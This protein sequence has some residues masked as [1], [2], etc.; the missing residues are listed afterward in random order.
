MIDIDRFKVINDTCG[1]IAGDEL[2]RQIASHVQ[3]DTSLYQKNTLGLLYA[4]EITSSFRAER[5][6]VMDGLLVKTEAERKEA[7]KGL[8]ERQAVVAKAMEKYPRR[9][10]TR[11]TS[12]SSWDSSPSTTPT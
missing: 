9:T 4:G 12:S 1:T 2:L 3:A 5:G 8:A 7:L 10:P 11:P 6:F